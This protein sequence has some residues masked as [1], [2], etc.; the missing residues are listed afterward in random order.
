MHGPHPVFVTTIPRSGTHLLDSVLER[1]PPFRRLPK[2]GV[3]AKLRHHPLNRLPG[4]DRCL[5]GIGRPYRVRLSTVGSRLRR[6]SP[7]EYGMG[8]LGYDTRV[9]DIVDRQGLRVI[10][11]IR[12][13]RDV[14]VSQYLLARDDRRHAFHDQVRAAPD[15]KSG[16]ELV[17][18]G[19]V[20]RGGRRKAGLAQ[21]FDLMAGWVDLPEVLTVRFEHLIG[22]RGGGEAGQQREQ[23]LAI[24][25]HIGVRLNA[26]MADRIGTEMFGKG[27]TFRRGVAGGW[28]DHLD[29]TLQQT[30]V[31]GLV[32]S[33]HRLGYAD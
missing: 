19:F 9:K 15:A 8:Q 12:D 2:L 27:R 6:I 32:E 14:L 31:A 33:A 25:D 21:Q 17:L 3:N 20:G 30:V 26:A 4:G 18:N 28:R 13:P 7:G 22:P 29:G 23:I 16:M 11:G 24:A 1:L 10:V 5:A